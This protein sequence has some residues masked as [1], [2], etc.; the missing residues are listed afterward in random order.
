M[1]SPRCTEPY[2][3]VL[4][5]CIQP[6]VARAIACVL[7]SVVPAV[8]YEVC[9]RAY[10]NGW[11][12]IFCSLALPSACLHQWIS[13]ADL[14]SNVTA[15]RLWAMFLVFLYITFPTHVISNNVAAERG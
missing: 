14:T 6:A 3:C 8:G 11:G 1:I 7:C 13:G 5:K 15:L 10:R 12:E 4:L 9:I 2:A